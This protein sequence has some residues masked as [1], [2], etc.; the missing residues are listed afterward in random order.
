MLFVP[1]RMTEDEEELGA[2]F[3]EHGILHDRKDYG[4]RKGAFGGSRSTR[5]RKQNISTTSLKQNPK[6][7]STEA[8]AVTIDNNQDES[9]HSTAG[10]KDKS[11]HQLNSRT[12]ASYVN[13]AFTI[14]SLFR[15]QK[16]N[17]EDK[18]MSNFSS[19]CRK[20]KTSWVH[21]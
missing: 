17:G 3:V 18:S 20:Q 7:S 13:E 14:S 5:K 9:T 15:Q 19:L 2:D 4:R 11:Q 12:E 10:N 21:Y 8:I 1:L 16:T 6:T